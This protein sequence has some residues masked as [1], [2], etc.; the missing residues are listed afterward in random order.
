MRRHQ[1]PQR[2]RPVVAYLVTTLAAAAATLITA[3]WSTASHAADAA[4][5]LRASPDDVAP[6]RASTTGAHDD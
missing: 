5:A 3:L 4:P 6:I 1:S 2:Q